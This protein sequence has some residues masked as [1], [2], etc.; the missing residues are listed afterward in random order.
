MR[1]RIARIHDQV[2]EHLLDLAAVRLDTS[3]R[4]VETQDDL[5][6]VADETVQ[7]RL[8]LATHAVEIEHARL[9]NLLATEGEQL[10]GERRRAPGGALNLADIRLEW[11]IIMQLI[12]QNSAVRLDD[13]EQV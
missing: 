5:N 2:D 3:D 7:H 10:L 11:I 4:L 8:Q 1:H 9:E 12:R 13:R 6:V